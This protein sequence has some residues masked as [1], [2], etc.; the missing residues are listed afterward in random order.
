NAQVLSCP[1]SEVRSAP[2]NIVTA[3]IRIATTTA[4][5]ISVH[6]IIWHTHFVLVGS[7]RGGICTLMRV[8]R[9]SYDQQVAYRRSFL[10][11][12]SVLSCW[13]RHRAR[14]PASLVRSAARARALPLGLVQ[15][16]GN[17]SSPPCNRCVRCRGSV[18]LQWGT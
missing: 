4:R 8:R 5:E 18:H 10:A 15:A 16:L 9:R 12:R 6:L 14:S 13:D 2:G 3:P 1:S 11:R 7:N 17:S